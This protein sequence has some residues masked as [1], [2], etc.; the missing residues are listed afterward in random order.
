MN[1]LEFNRIC[2]QNYLLY[3]NYIQ[4][5][6]INSIVSKTVRSYLPNQ[7]SIE[8]FEQCYDKWLKD[9]LRVCL[10]PAHPFISIDHDLPLA[11]I[12]IFT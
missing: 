10:L 4:R 12:M 11:Q 3:S 1:Y 6:I 5:S 9:F 2:A 8:N 7:L